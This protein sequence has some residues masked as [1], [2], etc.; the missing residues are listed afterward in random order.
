MTAMRRGLPPDGIDPAELI[1]EGRLFPFLPERT[2]DIREIF[3][4]SG[5]TRA[6]QAK[7]AAIG[8]GQTAPL[9]EKRPGKSLYGADFAVIIKV[10]RFFSGNIPV[11][12]VKDAGNQ[13]GRG[14]G[15]MPRFRAYFDFSPVGQTKNGQEI[16][17]GR[18]VCMADLERNTVF[19][20]DIPVTDFT[21]VVINK[22]TF[23]ELIQDIQFVVLRFRNEF[24]EMPLQISG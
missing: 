23:R 3:V 8:V 20:C 13:R 17:Q 5:L 16:V 15:G 22:D 4:E 1:E 12:A 21:G 11:A 7:G 18:P 6:R 10:I 9:Q 19:F 14:A 2:D 24:G